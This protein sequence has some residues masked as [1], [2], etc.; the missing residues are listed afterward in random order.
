[1]I[2]EAFKKECLHSNVSTTRPSSMFY[3]L[4][5]FSYKLFSKYSPLGESNLIFI[6][7]SNLE[8]RYCLFQWTDSDTENYQ[9]DVIHIMKLPIKQ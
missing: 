1:M 4:Q 3:S 2:I 5:V 6:I 8:K 7:I 9:C